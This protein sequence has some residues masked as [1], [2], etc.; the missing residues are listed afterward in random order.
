MTIREG[1]EM[2]T[3]GCFTP[4]HREIQ[5]S[6]A[7]ARLVFSSKQTD[8]FRQI[9]QEARQGALSARSAKMTSTSTSVLALFSGPSVTGKV[10]A[11]EIIA[12]DLRTTIYRVPLNQVVSKYIGETEKNLA[13][14]FE[15]AKKKKAVLFFDEADALLGKRSQVKD[16]HDRYANVEVNYLLAKVE[17]YR[18][19]VILTSNSNVDLDPTIVCRVKYLLEF[20]PPIPSPLFQP[21]R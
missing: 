16:A 13:G 14:V 3:T 1:I 11:A 20:S 21:R 5:S 10:I 6:K 2:M 9:A 12:K 8:T 19:L 18:G 4:A 7:G 17:A 15:T